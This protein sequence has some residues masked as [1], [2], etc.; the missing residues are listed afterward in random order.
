MCAH[1][2]TEGY[3]DPTPRHELTELTSPLAHPAAKRTA[4]SNRT[5][6]GRAAMWLAALSGIIVMTGHAWA[7]SSQRPRWKDVSPD[8]GSISDIAIAPSNPNYLYTSAGHLYRSLDG[9]ASWK[10]V[11]GQEGLY[12]EE[13]LVD[14]ANATTLYSLSSDLWKSTDAGKEWTRVLYR[15]HFTSSSIYCAAVSDSSSNILYAGTDGDGVLKSTDGGTTWSK[16][17]PGI[18]DDWVLTLAVDPQNP[19]VVFAGSMDHLFKTSDGGARWADCGQGLPSDLISVTSVSISP[20]MP[21]LV[22]VGCYDDGLFRSTDGGGTWKLAGDWPRRVVSARL[23]L[24]PVAVDI[25]YT[26]TDEGAFMTT[27]GGKKWTAM[28]GLPATEI[29]RIVIDPTDQALLYAGTVSGV[30]KSTDRGVTWSSAST[31]I[32]EWPVYSVDVDPSNPQIVFA[33][34][35]GGVFKSTDAG[36]TWRSSHGNCRTFTYVD[37]V[38]VDPNTP[39]VVYV[40]GESGTYKSMD[41]G[42]TWTRIYQELVTL[43]VD[44]RTPTTL[45]GG[46]EQVLKSTDGGSTWKPSSHFADGYVS[47]IAI[48][49]FATATIYAGNSSSGCVWKSTD[50]GSDWGCAL[51]VRD[52]YYWYGWGIT[53]DPESSSTVYA[54][55]AAGPKKLWKSTDGGQSWTG[56][57]KGRAVSCLQVSPATTGVLYAGTLGQGVYKS[58]DGGSTW[59]SMNAGF[60]RPR[61]KFVYALRAGQGAGDFTYAATGAGLYRVADQ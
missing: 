46:N 14:P 6:V 22:Y 2:L 27:A 11:P 49:P 51:V 26:A 53:I 4:L 17:G 40:S 28:L 48:D 24:D 29:A 54:Y 60:L 9:A 61:S 31:G 19:A 15:G 42:A 12:H 5:S 33:G 41:G 34:T 35:D 58:T 18:G 7:G 36:R 13:L 3:R 1:L 8:G 32:R 57:M 39:G 44:S 25:L 21:D 59:R 16:T 10:A 45:Y 38:T 55:A 52:P 43:A 30:Y 56:M 47:A 20:A 50:G 37:A 23:T